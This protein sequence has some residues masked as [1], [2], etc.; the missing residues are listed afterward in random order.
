MPRLIG[1]GHDLAASGR[2]GAAQV[3]YGRFLELDPQ[4]RGR[5]RDEIQLYAQSGY[6]RVG[7]TE[8]A[9]S[10]PDIPPAPATASPAALSTAAVSPAPLGPAI[11]PF[12]RPPVAYNP[13]KQ[14]ELKLSIA[15]DAFQRGDYNGAYQWA[16]RANEAMPQ[17]R[18]HA[19][20][21]QALLAQG[22]YSGAA[23]EARAA[24][25]M[26][27]VIDWTTLYGFYDYKMPEYSAFPSV[28]KFCAAE[29]VVL[30]RAVPAGIRASDPWPGRH[31]ARPNGDFGRA[32]ARGRRAHE[33]AGPRRSGD[34]WRAANGDKK[35]AGSRGDRR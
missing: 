4:A 11:A 13:A 15:Q 14:S 9:L 21:A 6:A 27:P 26:G 18:I 22:F 20:M 32:R 24:A 8:V 5:T 2:S 10:R 3:D 23:G 19:L 16:Q 29:S 25:A 31:R 34:R 7:E 1:S 33:H 35:H 28:G 30:R 12:I 17:A